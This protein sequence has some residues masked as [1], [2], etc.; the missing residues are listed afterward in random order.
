MRAGYG[1]KLRNYFIDFTQPLMLID[2][3]SGIFDSATV[4][5]NL[6]LLK[7]TRYRAP[8]KSYTLKKINANDLNFSSHFSKNHVLINFEKD[9]PW[10]IINGIE[11]EIRFKIEKNGIRLT[12]IKNIKINYGIKTGLNDVFI[13]NEITRNQIIKNCL[14]ELERDKTIEIIKPVLRGKDIKQGSYKWANLYII[15][16]TFNSHKYIPEQYPSLYS[17]LNKFKTP[18]SKRGQVRYKSNGTVNDKNEDNY[19]GYPGMHHWLELDNNVNEDTIELLL[20]PKII[21][22]EIVREPQFYLDKDGFIPEASSF[23]LIAEDLEYIVS[24]LNNYIVAWTFKVFYSGGGLGDDG[25]R[26]KKKFIENLRI[27]LKNKKFKNIFD[28]SD[29]EITYIQNQ[30]K[31]KNS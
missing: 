27:P 2:L 20:K 12:D 17:Y 22:S 10:S 19:N 8:T 5:T 6:I 31:I 4:D 26:Y 11:Q 21:Y 7:K 13:V 1:E 29:Q 30:L 9:L 23:Y 24:M 16:A 25:F 28:L 3:G 15:L 18:L 14:T